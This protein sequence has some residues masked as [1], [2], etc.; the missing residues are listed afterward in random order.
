MKIEAAYTRWS[1]TYDADRNLTRD[2][3]ASVTR[4]IL[5]RRR[6]RSALELGCGTGKNTAFLARISRTVLALDFSRGMLERAKEKVEARNVAF[7][8]ADLTKPWPCADGS[9]DVVTFNLVLEHVDDLNFVFEEAARCAMDGGLVFVSELHPYRQYGGS[10]A[11]YEDQ[12]NEVV[13]VP[14]FTHHVSDFLRSARRAGLTL[15]AFTEERHPDDEHRLP[16]LAVFELG[17][18]RRRPG[19]VSPL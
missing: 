19:M 8:L 10:R 17:R 15:E 5:G 11:K 7:A 18:G 3:D 13:S 6:F 9:F 1:S 2:L 12:P 14:A 16:R 4:R